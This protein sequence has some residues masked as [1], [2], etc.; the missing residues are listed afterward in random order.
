MT[1]FVHM[2]QPVSPEQKQRV[3]DLRRSHSLADVA[4]L[5]TF[6]L[7]AVKT[8]NSRSGR[9]SSNQAHRPLFTLPAIQPSS[10]TLEVD[11]RF[12]RCTALMPQTLSDCLRELGYWSSLYW[13]RNAVKHETNR[14]NIG[15]FDRTM[16][17]STC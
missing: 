5:T 12:K 7:G 10:Q 9:F 14:V 6:P 3:L 8:I 17:D 4:G 16:T 2:K 1:V 15:Q 13:L 11:S